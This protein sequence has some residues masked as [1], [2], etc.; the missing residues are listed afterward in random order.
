MDGMFWMCLLFRIFEV[1]GCLF[2]RI[3]EKWLFVLGDKVLEFVFIGD[4]MKIIK[5]IF[6]SVGVLILKVID[7]Y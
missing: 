7:G 3:Q 2:L 4:N 6:L 5:Y 1:G